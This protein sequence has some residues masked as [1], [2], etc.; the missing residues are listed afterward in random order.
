[1]GLFQQDSVV[2]SMKMILDQLGQFLRG[3]STFHNKTMFIP[4]S[5]K[6]APLVKRLMKLRG[7]LGSMSD[8]LYV[9]EF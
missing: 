8:P 3:L 9:D 6:W 2:A 5:E 7:F 1:M 4:K